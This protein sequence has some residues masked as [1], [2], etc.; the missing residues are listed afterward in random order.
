M[1]PGGS[2]GIPLEAP[3]LCNEGNLTPLRLHEH[4]EEL[5]QFLSLPNEGPAETNPEGGTNHEK[6]NPDYFSGFCF[7][8]TWNCLCGRCYAR[9]GHAAISG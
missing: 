9:G 6:G 7:L 4:L 3:S 8:G 5:K 1:P 2:L